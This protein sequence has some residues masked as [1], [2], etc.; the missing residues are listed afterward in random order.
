MARI[1]KACF[2]VGCAIFFPVYIIDISTS[3]VVGVGAVPGSYERCKENADEILVLS[4][5]VYCQ[6]WA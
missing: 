5:T 2:G 4:G 1:C 6:S 3:W